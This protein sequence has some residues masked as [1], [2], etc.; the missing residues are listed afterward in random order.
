M[1][2]QAAWAGQIRAD[3]LREIDGGAEAGRAMRRANRL[4]GTGDIPPDT[5]ELDDE[6]D[7]RGS[8]KGEGV[9][10]NHDEGSS[11]PAKM[12]T[13]RLL[14]LSWLTLVPSFG[15]SLLYIN[16]HAFM[17]NIFPSV[18]G[19]LGEEWFP[20]QAALGKTS[21]GAQIANKSLGVAEK[22]LLLFLDILLV[23]IIL[24]GLAVIMMII[25]FFSGFFGT[26]F[27]WLWKL[28]N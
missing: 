1:A 19:K 26:I 7:F 16:A 9:L 22:M 15:L 3:R 17:H 13:N 12:A 8:N 28:T 6:A 10:N 2:N 21:S 27:G 18:F 5:A 14:S 24:M 25:D 11:S 4:G 20:G 23:L